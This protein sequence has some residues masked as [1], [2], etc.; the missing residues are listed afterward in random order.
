RGPSRPRGSRLNPLPAVVPLV[1][2]RFDRATAAR[3][4]GATE[5]TVQWGGRC[6][7]RVVADAPGEGLARR[8]LVQLPRDTTCSSAVR[9]VPGRL[10]SDHPHPFLRTRKGPSA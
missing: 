5:W 10:P 9:S 4:E 3:I 2:E 7:A 8:P 1:P 6:R